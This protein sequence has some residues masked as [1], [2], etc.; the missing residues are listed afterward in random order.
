M[1][2]RGG[3]QFWERRTGEGGKEVQ[4]RAVAAAG[5]WRCHGR[6]GSRNRSEE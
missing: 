4:R 1:G 5:G 6:R 2:E 3:A